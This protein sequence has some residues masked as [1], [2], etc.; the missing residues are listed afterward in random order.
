MN[1]QSEEKLIKINKTK[2]PKTQSA[3]DLSLKMPA[4][5]KKMPTGKKS[6]KKSTSSVMTQPPFPTEKLPE[7]IPEVVEPSQSYRQ[8]IIF[9]VE[10]YK[11]LPYL[12]TYRGM[13]FLLTFIILAATL[14]MGI[15]EPASDILYGLAFV[16]PIIYLVYRSYRW[17]YVIAILW[18]CVEKF[19]QI[20]TAATFPL[21]VSALMWLAIGVWVYYR[22]FAVE[23]MRIKKQRAE[24]IPFRKWPVIRDSLLSVVLFFV[25]AMVVAIILE[26]YL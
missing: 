15:V 11:T 18:W 19:T 22:A 24:G 12:K 21:V 26:L 16:V 3:K 6:A 4:E 8:K 13:S 2:K 1:I 23:N 14:V 20:F 10:N 5:I 17:S 25:T 7:T 9:Q